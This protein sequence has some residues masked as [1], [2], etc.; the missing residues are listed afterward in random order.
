VKPDTVKTRLFRARKHLRKMLDEKFAKAAPEMF[1][2]LGH[3]C[4]QTTETVLHRLAPL[5]GWTD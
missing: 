2:F 4:A 1:P 3:A 5:Y